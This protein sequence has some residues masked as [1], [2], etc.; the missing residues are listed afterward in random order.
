MQTRLRDE[1]GMA[2]VLGLL[3][4]F[5]VLVLSSV[6]VAQNIRTSNQSA[7]VRKRVQAVAAA[8]AG[9]NDF[10]AHLRNVT[11]DELRCTPRTGTVASAPDDAAFTVTPTFYDANGQV[12]ACPAADPTPFTDEVYPA[13]VLLESEGTV[14]GQVPRTIQTYVELEPILD[15]FDAAI[16]TQNGMSLNNNLTLNGNGGTDADIFVNTG[17]LTVSNQPNIYGSVYVSAGNARLE[18]NSSIRGDL[19]ANGSVTLTTGS[20]VY[21][22]VISSTSSISVTTP[23][24]VYGDATA[25][26]T[27]ADSARIDGLET[28]NSPQGPPPSQPLPRVYWDAQDWIDAGYTITTFSDCTSARTWLLNPANTSTST[29]KVVRISTVCALGFRN[30]DDINVGGDLAIVTDGSISMSQSVDWI[31]TSGSQHNLFFISAYRDGLDCSTGAYDVSDSNNVSYANITGVSF[32]SPCTV[33]INNRSNMNGQ[34]IGGTVRIT[35]Q[36]TMNFVPVLIPGVGDVVGF[37]Q[38]IA[39]I[40][41]VRS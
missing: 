25:G 11:I 39:Y 14:S 30:N 38:D 32:Y 29:K 36:F 9:T 19:W 12:M 10:Y 15:G 13:A 26:T 5:I 4:A 31:G 37:E 18:N 3:V 34:V 1:R 33:T 40:R 23:A 20:T 35:N 28:P 16:I 8:E 17:N 24:R 27:I 41:E 6:V 2:M 7:Y 22:D 21:Q